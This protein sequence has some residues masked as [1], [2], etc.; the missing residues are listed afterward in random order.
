MFSLQNRER[1]VRIS[2]GSAGLGRIVAADMLG[3]QQGAEQVMVIWEFGRVAI[4]DLGT[5]H[6]PEELGDVKLGSGKTSEGW[7]IRREK[8]KA[9]GKS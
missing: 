5:G 4:W 2:N 1:K 3:L 7:A 9:E 6:A 8:G